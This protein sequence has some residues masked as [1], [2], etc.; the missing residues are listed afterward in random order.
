VLVKSDVTRAIVNVKVGKGSWEKK[1]QCSNW[2]N[3][4]DEL[5]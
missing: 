3:W 1:K 5:L 4:E 2:R